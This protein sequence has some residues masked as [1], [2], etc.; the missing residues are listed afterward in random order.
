MSAPL[1]EI[2]GLRVDVTSTG[3]NIVKDIDLTVKKGEV[4]ALIGESGSGKTTI[5][6][7]ALGY[8]RP[9]LRVT[10]GSVRFDGD[11]ILTMSSHERRS[12]RGHRIAYVAQS[13][14]ASFNPGLSIGYQVTEPA[15]LHS[16][17]DPKQA[18]DHA[19]NLYKQMLLP[20]PERI[21][22]RFPHEV[23]GGQLQRLMAAM[24][25]SCDPDLVIFDEPT[26]ALDVTTQIDVLK[27][28][29]DA[30]REREAAAIYV[31][32]D[33]AVVAQI[34]DR[35]FVLL[36][37]E[38]VETG[39]TDELINDPKHNYTRLLMAA[40]DPDKARVRSR[41]AA[42]SASPTVSQPTNLQ[43]KSLWAGYGGTDN[44]GLPKVSVLKDISMS[45]AKGSIV[46]VIGESGSGKSTLARAVAGF[47]PPA[48]GE[49]LLDGK[50]LPRAI[51]DR[52]RDQLRQ[53]QMVTQM[54]DTALNPSQTIGKILRR[55]VQFLRGASG[56]E[57]D[58][59]VEELMDKVKLDRDLLNRRPKELSGGQKQRINLARALAADP[60]LILCDEV[61]SALD[62][63]VRNSIIDLIDE[64]R[65]TDG[66]SFLFISHDIST[67]ATLADEVVVM[68]QGEIVENGQTE[69]VINAPEHAYTKQLMTAV[70]HLRQGWLEEALANRSRAQFVPNPTDMKEVET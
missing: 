35:I 59:I 49:V 24:G 5:A 48:K 68:Y 31:S 26:T 42:V 61:T 13:A 18:A 55:P 3:A 14:A 12:I 45:V 44:N 33:L 57:C 67:I 60:M 28:F 47:L 17:L 69:N 51:S 29:K 19:H 8:T 41:P 15:A 62:T 10:S 34:A 7:S 43:V 20:D 4:V 16:Y 38:V 66:I 23:S 53:V 9:G 56:S 65:E 63:V 32:H 2:S 50:S 37:G 25:L 52:S 11:D 58:G 22:E 39:T 64:L 1:L 30:I 54:A 40:C 21:G 6:L 36:N 27:V 46:G 70:P